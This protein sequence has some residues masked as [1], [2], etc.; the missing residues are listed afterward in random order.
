MQKRMRPNHLGT[1][2]F[3]GIASGLALATGASAL[4][5]DSSNSG[6]DQGAV[7][8]DTLCITPLYNLAASAPVSGSLDITGTTLNFNIQLANASFNP[9]GGSDG[10]ITALSLSN[11][12]Y[13]GSIA[14]SPSGSTFTV[15]GGQVGSVSGT[16]T[17]TGAGSAAPIA[18]SL[19]LVTGVC[20]GTPGSSLQ[21][22]LIFGPAVDFKAT[23]NGNVRYFRTTVDAFTVV[24]EPGTALLL[25]LGLVGLSTGRRGRGVTN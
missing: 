7:C 15:N 22:G 21:C 8:S 14:V 9:V 25:G 4:S 23:V 3:L 12:T 11:L 2:L 13:S 20:S 10:G 5:I 18:A 17:P 19:V 16:A 24:P 6:V 1:G